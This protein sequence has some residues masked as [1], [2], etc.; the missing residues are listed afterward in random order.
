MRMIYL[1]NFINEIKYFKNIVNF[2]SEYFKKRNSEE[3]NKNEK[4][5][6]YLI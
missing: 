2:K 5:Y 4:L 1:E 3:I 6:L